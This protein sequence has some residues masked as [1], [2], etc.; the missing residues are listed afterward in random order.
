VLLLVDS[1]NRIT[2]GISLSQTVFLLVRDVYVHHSNVI[3]SSRVVKLNGISTPS[4]DLVTGSF[5]G[6][7]H[8]ACEIGP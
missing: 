7:L 4:T 3:S 2:I 1:S 6:A 5:V 8:F